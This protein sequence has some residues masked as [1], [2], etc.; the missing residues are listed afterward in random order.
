MTW[1]AWTSEQTV[2]VQ[3]PSFIAQ[4]AH[5]FE[6]RA[7]VAGQPETADREPARAEFTIDTVAP[8][9]T[10][11]REGSELIIDAHDEVT[12]S[13]RLEYAYAFDGREPGEWVREPRA[14]IPADATRYA[15]RVRDGA[16]N[17]VRVEGSLDPL[18]I[19]GGPSTDEGSGCGCSTPGARR[20]GLDALF[21]AALAAASAIFL[22]RRRVTRR[23]TAVAPTRRLGPSARTLLFWGVL[24]LFFAGLGCNCG[25]SVQPDGGMEGGSITCDGGARY[26]RAM[27]RCVAPATCRCM[28]GFEATGSPRFN[29]MTCTFDTSET[30]CGCQELPP[31]SQGMTGSHL[32]MAVHSDNTVWLSAYSAGDP[33]SQRPYGDLI[34]GQY[35]AMTS[36]VRWQIVDGVP[37]DADVEAAPSGWRGGIAAPG[38]DVGRWNSI[39]VTSAGQPRVAYWDTTND[40]LK[41]ASFDGTRWSTHVVDTQGRNG[42]YASLVLLTGDVPAIAYRATV[43]DPMTPGRVL[44]R[45]RYARANNATPRAASDWTITDVASAPTQCRANDCT[46][47]QVCV[48]ET[49]LCAAP[50]GMCPSACGTGQAC[51]EGRCQDTY[52]A[53]WVEDFPP[54]IGLF[55]SLA[56]DAMQ[57]PQ[58]VYYDR[59]RGN[60]MGARAGSDGMWSAPFVIDGEAMMRDGGDRGA[61]AS[62]AVAAD[63]TWHVAYVDG[64]E[65]RLLYAVVRDGARV[66]SPEVIDD[67]AGLGMTAFDDGRHLVGD[68]AAIN[69]D[70]MGA[71]R[72]VYQDA[73]AGTLRLATRGTTGWTTSVLDMMGHT[74]Y[75][76]RIERGQIATFFRDLSV[77]GGRFGVRVQPV[78]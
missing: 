45:V 36:S 9:A 31:L 22:A 43:P 32:D 19:R 72:V 39:A 15:V 5:V 23:A 56:V 34:V 41:F 10:A 59:D 51:V 27:N 61:W 70:A 16:G 18:L 42:R 78:R 60:L 47:G 54:G 24:G 69:V 28:P 4:G 13:D 63:G 7:R 75:W 64:Y 44:A 71:V 37:T 29:E 33:F 46:A 38:P 26:C 68:S 40:K 11:T 14:R 12:P 21:A 35:N 30:A 62:L 55:N 49:G 3:S 48:R 77:R 66:G 73:T 20:T 58:L 74:G 76:A 25:S 17:D 2:E 52:T 6:V 53:T 65:E 50:S 67:G 1:S 8:T 57:R